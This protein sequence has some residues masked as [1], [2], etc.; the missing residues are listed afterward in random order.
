[1]THR[2]SN[3]VTLL[4]GRDRTHCKP[5]TRQSKR[6]RKETH[7]E[8]THVSPTPPDTPVQAAVPSHLADC[9]LLPPLHLCSLSHTV[10]TLQL[11][12]YFWSV[13]LLRGRPCQLPIAPRGILTT[14]CQTLHDPL[15]PRPHLPPL[16][17]GSIHSGHT[18]LLTAPRAHQACSGLGALAPTVPSAP[19]SL[20]RFLRASRSPLM[21]LFK[22]APY[23]TPCHSVPNPA[24]FFFIAFSPS[25]TLCITLLSISTLHKAS[26]LKAGTLFTAVSAVPRTVPGTCW[27]PRKH[28][29]NEH[30]CC[31]QGDLPSA[32]WGR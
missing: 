25:G 3:W 20:L 14:I 26:S 13:T 6:R 30:M 12:H 1:M 19:G 7:P 31:L 10:I 17:P 5:T 21:A 9:S 18:D 24:L 28:L 15:P 22:I 8:S 16:P 2:Q 27:V 32:L 23:P 11:E 29:F 4:C